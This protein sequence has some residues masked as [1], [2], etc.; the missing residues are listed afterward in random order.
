MSGLGRAAS[1][2]C[3]H[4]DTGVEPTLGRWVKLQAQGLGVAFFFLA[5]CGL[6]RVVGAKISRARCRMVSLT[7]FGLSC[8]PCSE[9]MKLQ[10]WMVPDRFTSFPSAWG[11]SCQAPRKG[12]CGHREVHHKHQSFPKPLSIF[13][14]AGGRW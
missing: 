11:C 3:S 14:Q 12:G 4:G 7:G 6:G 1:H 8:W 9:V 10:F 2:L 13:R 5:A